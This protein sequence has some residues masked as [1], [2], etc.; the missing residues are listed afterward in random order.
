MLKAA[1][2]E[3]LGQL[4]AIHVVNGVGIVDDCIHVYFESQTSYDNASKAR[5]HLYGLNGSGGN[6]RADGAQEVTCAAM[7]LGGLSVGRK[8]IHPAAQDF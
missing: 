1:K 3:Y 4:F 5:K 2:K 6:L 8:P 7:Q